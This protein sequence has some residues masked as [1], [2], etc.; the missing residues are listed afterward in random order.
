VAGLN[1]ASAKQAGQVN[2]TTK[3]SLQ[4]AEFFESKVRPLLHKSCFQ[5]HGQTMQMGELRLDSLAA[6]LKGNSH[7]PALIAGE[8]EKS[9]LIKAIRYTGKI[10][11]PP[12]GKL[13]QVEIDTLTDW[14]RR[15]APW[16]SAVITDSAKDA[17]KT[18]D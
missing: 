14:V 15:G 3:V 7:G 17:A 9:S 1:P 2:A 5:C 10:K 4:D 6:V 16:P 13:S 12:A 8:P 18:G 11:M